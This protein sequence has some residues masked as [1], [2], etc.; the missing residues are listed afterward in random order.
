MVLPFLLILL[1]ALGCSPAAPTQQFNPFRHHDS[2]F[3]WA[4]VHQ[5]TQAWN[6]TIPAAPSVFP[7]YH[8]I[9]ANRPVHSEKKSVVMN[10]YLLDTV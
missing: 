8:S 2:R 1:S 3:I 4:D 5:Q 9:P 10:A 6:P 7:H